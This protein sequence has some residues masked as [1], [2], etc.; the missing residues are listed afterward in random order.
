MIKRRKPRIT[1]YATTKEI[2]KEV[3]GGGFYTIES[4][5]NCQITYVMASDEMLIMQDD[6]T[7]RIPAQLFS[8]IGALAIDLADNKERGLL[9]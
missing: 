9:R 1:A 3:E 6:C 2:K 8:E 4:E 5:I 7:Y